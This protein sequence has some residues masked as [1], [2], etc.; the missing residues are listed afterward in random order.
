MDIKPLNIYIDCIILV[1]MEL[2]PESR[3]ISKALTGEYQKLNIFK[4]CTIL[5]FIEL[6][7]E[8]GL[9]S[10]TFT[11]KYILKDYTH[12]I[13]LNILKLMAVRPNR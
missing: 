11:E 9:I 8:S 7:P 13:S 3:P 6:N 1:Y 12:D 5:V 2:N 10:K 4:D